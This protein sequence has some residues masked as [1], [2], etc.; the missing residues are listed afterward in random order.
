MYFLKMYPDCKTTH[1]LDNEDFII[2]IFFPWGYSSINMYT[3]WRSHWGGKGGQSATPD[4]KKIAENREKI[5]KNRGKIRKNREKR[6]KIGKK[7]QKSGRFFHFAP[8]DRWAGYATVYTCITRG[9]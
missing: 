3:Q 8:P 4:S 2:L 5:R 1:K 7:R 9:F 6:G